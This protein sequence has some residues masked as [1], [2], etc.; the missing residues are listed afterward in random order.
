MSGEPPPSI[1]APAA[2]PYPRSRVTPS[3]RALIDVS[4]ETSSPGRLS[5]ELARVQRSQRFLLDAS[6]VLAHASGVAETLQALALVA[7]PTL[8]DLCLIDVLQG[9]DRM[10]RM[11]AT[12]ADETKQPLVDQLRRFYPPDPHGRHPSVE[13]MRVKQTRWSP[14]MP[15]DFLQNTT[16]DERHY[17]L[18][19]ELGF[20]SYMCVPLVAADEVLGSL[21]IVSAGSGRRFG[22]DDVALAEDLADRVALVVAKERRY[23]A[24]RQV[25][26]TLQSSLLP[27][28]LPEIEGLSLAVRYLPGTRDAEVGGDFWDVVQLPD[29]EAAFVLGDVAG[30]DMGAAAAMGQLRSACRALR[31]QTTTPGDL[32]A[33]MH[34][35]WGQLGIDR[36]ATAIFARIVPSSGRLRVA[37]AG[38]PAPVIAEPGTATLA[39]LDPASPFG[40]PRHLGTGWETTL[41]RGAAIVFYTDGLVEDR[42]RDIDEGTQR[43]LSVV[44]DAPTLDPD[45]LAD[46]LISAVPPVDRDDDVAILIARRD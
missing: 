17:R 39:A 3:Q 31:P 33:L 24:A 38:H 25:S 45:T 2:E 29:G 46:H 19:K 20:T 22:P 5:A 9:R 15:D 32:V 10:V 26:H 40:A 6:M 37:S 11:A 44:R 4:G 35:T 13:A 27:A 12:H 14:E 23:D 28:E 16:R 36:I 18:V 7:V 34:D 8:G 1:D 41:P 43:L 21:T 42:G 30:H